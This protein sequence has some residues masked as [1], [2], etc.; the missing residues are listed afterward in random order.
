MLENYWLRRCSPADVE[1]LAKAFGPDLAPQPPGNSDAFWRCSAAVTPDGRLLG[2]AS[3]CTELYGQPLRPG[4]YFLQVAVV[5]EFRGQGIGEALYREAA[6]AAQDARATRLDCCVRPADGAARAFAAT[7]GF[8][9]DY[10]MLSGELDLTA[11]DPTPWE[12]ATRLEGIRFST[13]A[14][15]NATDATLRQ[16]YELDR[17]V[18][19]DVPQWAGEMP[20]YD[21]YAQNLLA[22]DPEGAM[23]A[24]DGDSLAGFAFSTVE[25]DGETGYT[26]FLGVARYYRG[27]GLALALKLRTIGWARSRGLRRLRTHN[28]AASTSIVA[29]NR[30][31]GFVMEPDTDYLV[32]TFPSVVSHSTEGRM[33]LQGEHKFGG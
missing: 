32:K 1:A 2:Y 3:L 18:S 28:N 26:D 21:R 25:E 33:S 27:K 8:R 30:K 7:R 31:L 19:A 20:P 29:L 5:P 4:E 12:A 14:R 11:F 16:I 6:E 9:L 23:L 15:E 13:L 22:G 17:Q 10:S 24:W